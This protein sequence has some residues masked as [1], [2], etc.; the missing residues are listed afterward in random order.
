MLLFIPLK[1]TLLDSFLARKVS[2]GCEVLQ[3][4][5]KFFLKHLDES[6]LGLIKAHVS[7]HIIKSHVSVYVHIMKAH[8]SVHIVGVYT[9][10]RH[11]TGVHMIKHT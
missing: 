3:I 9:L 5:K 2:G 6:M 8:A 10:S 7:V 11:T 1:A 4:N